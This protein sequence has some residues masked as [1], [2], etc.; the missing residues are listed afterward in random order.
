M[1][2]VPHSIRP[3]SAA[4]RLNQDLRA[5]ACLRP[6]PCDRG[7]RRDVE[8]PTHR[9]VVVREAGLLPRHLLPV[10]TAPSGRSRK[11]KKPQTLL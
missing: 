2:R 9:S 7:F 6:P 11:G 5:M 1:V 3:A 4:S 10:Q 8:R